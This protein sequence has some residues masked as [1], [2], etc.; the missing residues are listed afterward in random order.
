V[1][2]WP[3]EVHRGVHGGERV[4]LVERAR[5][6]QSEA[7]PSPWR[8]QTSCKRADVAAFR[9]MRRACDTFLVGSYVARAL[10]D[11]VGTSVEVWLA[12]TRRGC[13]PAP[14]EGGIALE[15]GSFAGDRLGAVIEVESP[16][17]VA[18]TARALK[19]PPPKLVHG[20]GDDAVQALAGGLA[21]IV[22][23]MSRREEP[24]LPFD[25]AGPIRVLDAGASARLFAERREA[26]KAVDVATFGVAIEGEAFVARA[27][28]DAE[29]TQERR[30]RI[31]RPFDKGRLAR[32]GRMPL[33]IPIVAATYGT[34][35]ADL[36]ALEVG[37]AFMLGAADWARALLGDVVLAAPVAEWGARAALVA[38]GAVVLRAGREDIGLDA[39]PHEEAKDT[40]VEA[41]G[42]VPIVVRVE[43]GTARMTAREWAELSVGDVVGL[44][45]KLAEPVTLRV[46]GVEVAKGELVDIEGEIGVRILSRQGS[47]RAP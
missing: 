2:F 30:A 29:A 14:L 39:M 24:G 20:A 31:D 7:V 40:L 22:V 4:R 47:E 15:M 35:A 6:L 27:V 32:L 11:L 26:W 43:V 19:R 5:A 25:V 1:P 42:E 21:A 44:A 12:D 17:A 41:I 33:E 13:A 3:N 36:A 34:S 37:D 46:G 9:R 16:L 18:V 10:Q 28:V 45:Q 23:A 38:N 8:P